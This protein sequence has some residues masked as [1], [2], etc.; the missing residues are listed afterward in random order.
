[1]INDLASTAICTASCLS[2]DFKE[3]V[4]EDFTIPVLEEI[5]TELIVKPVYL[6]TPTSRIN[7]DSELITLFEKS[8]LEISL[9]I[10]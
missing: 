10:S 3:S 1:L 6:L 9:V 2:E 4:F 5:G 8:A 7:F